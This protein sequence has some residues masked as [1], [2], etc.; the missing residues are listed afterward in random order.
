M[1]SRP[2]RVVAVGCLQPGDFP[3][4]PRLLVHSCAAQQPCSLAALSP[5]PSIAKL[6]HTKKNE[7]SEA[8]SH[9]NPGQSKGVGQSTLVLISLA[10]R[11]CCS[12]HHD[13]NAPS[14]WVPV[15]AGGAQVCEGCITSRQ[16]KRRGPPRR[17]LPLRVYTAVRT[18]GQA[19]RLVLT[20]GQHHCPRRTNRAEGEGKGLCL[21]PMHAC[22]A[23]L[24]RQHGDQAS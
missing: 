21:L 7:M 6:V 23:C 4:R 19:P 16:A 24:V 14:L 17:A 11:S 1:A 20:Q 5:S 15:P 3:C 18:F 12:C 22:R 2:G 9:I 13:R 8:L 10:G